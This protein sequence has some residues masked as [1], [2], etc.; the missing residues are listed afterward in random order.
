[1]PGAGLESR[2]MEGRSVNAFLTSNF[3]R[4]IGVAD[5]GRT[6]NRQDHAL[7]SYGRARRSPAASGSSPHARRRSGIR[8]GVHGPGRHARRRRRG[9][10]DR[11]ARPTNARH[12]PGAVAHRQRR[13]DR[14]ARGRGRV[15]L[16]DRAI[17]RERPGPV[18]DRRS[19]MAR[20]LQ[21][22][23]PRIRR[24]SPHRTRRDPGQC[25][26][27]G[28]RRR[29]RDLAAVATARGDQPCSPESVER[30]RLA[31][32][33]RLRLRRSFSRPAMGR[34]HEVSGG[35]PF[36]AIELARALNE[37]RP[38]PPSPRFRAHSAMSSGVGSGA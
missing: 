26:H 14:S 34:I 11:P 24:A 38:V 30:P 27:R 28:R 17:R 4:A 6:R 12:R 8:A 16:S 29:A 13:R 32:R 2:P 35:N 37:R 25:A 9:D 7:V 23:R 21:H 5:R 15:P 33:G 31:R 10:V 1:M 19:A 22:S 3:R 18:G 20:S 36:Y